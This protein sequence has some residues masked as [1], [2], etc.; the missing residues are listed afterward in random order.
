MV[1][2]AS[3]LHWMTGQRKHTSETK[4]MNMQARSTGAVHFWISDEFT[5]ECFPYIAHDCLDGTAATTTG[6]RAARTAVTRMLTWSK[7]K[8]TRRARMSV[9]QNLALVKDIRKDRS[10]QEREIW[11]WIINFFPACPQFFILIICLFLIINNKIPYN[12]NVT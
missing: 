7:R 5:R 11:R 12:L 6:T 2:F 8:Y 9:S 4:S 10:V 3:I 1:L